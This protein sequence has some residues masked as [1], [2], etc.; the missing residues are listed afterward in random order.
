MR[1]QHCSCIR[2]YFRPLRSSLHAACTDECVRVARGERVQRQVQRGGR[3]CG[4]G[5]PPAEQPSS[6]Q[7]AVNSLMNTCCHTVGVRAP[8]VLL[9]S[10]SAEFL[11]L[12]VQTLLVRLRLADDDL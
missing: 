8:Q 7:S 12:H 2:V 9:T 10:P 11:C 3:R 4:L 6:H 5:Q 1:D